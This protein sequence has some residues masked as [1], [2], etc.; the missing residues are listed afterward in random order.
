MSG[1][2]LGDRC[3]VSGTG[4]VDIVPLAVLALYHC[5]KAGTDKSPGLYQSHSDEPPDPAQH[6]LEHHLAGTAHPPAYTRCMYPLVTLVLHM[7][8]LLRTRCTIVVLDYLPHTRLC[9][10]PTTSRVALDQQRIRPN[11]SSDQQLIRPTTH[12]TNNSDAD[13]I[14]DPGY[15][16]VAPHAGRR[17]PRR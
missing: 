12:Q 8:Y 17:P 3:A 15:A 7:S 10:R 1:T 13:R 9:T 5:A 16:A 4:A 6:V 2:D 11:N 14:G